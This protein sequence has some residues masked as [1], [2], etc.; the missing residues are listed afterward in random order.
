MKTLT[1]LNNLIFAANT[2]AT[3]MFN[4][5]CPQTVEDYENGLDMDKNT[6]KYKRLC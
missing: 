1:K 4:F 3:D 6:S 2:Y 5:V